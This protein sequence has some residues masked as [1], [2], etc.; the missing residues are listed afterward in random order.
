[1]SASAHH[2]WIVKASVETEGAELE[3][4]SVGGGAGKS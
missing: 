3:S 2:S 1:M 4:L